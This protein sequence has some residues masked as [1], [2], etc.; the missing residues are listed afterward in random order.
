MAKF[1][2]KTGGICEVFSDSNIKRLR[3]DK[4]FTEIRDTKAIV[5]EQKPVQENKNSDK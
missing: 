1:K 3:E 4:N 2:N 5:S